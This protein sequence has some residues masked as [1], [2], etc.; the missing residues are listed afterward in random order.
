MPRA[1]HGAATVRAVAASV[2]AAVVLAVAAAWWVHHRVIPAER[3][4]LPAI[5]QTVVVAPLPPQSRPDL[6]E[7]PRDPVEEAWCEHGPEAVVRDTEPLARPDRDPAAAE[8]DMRHAWLRCEA[9]F[10]LGRVDQ[11]LTWSRRMVDALARPTPAQPVEPLVLEQHARVRL[12]AGESNMDKLE[13]GLRACV[14]ARQ[15][16]GGSVPDLSWAT[17]GALQKARGDTEQAV[18]SHDRALAGLDAPAWLAMR[19]REPWRLQL[20]ALAAMDRADS[21]VSLGR[22]ADARAAAIQLASD[23]AVALGEGEPLVQQAA[24]LRDSITGLK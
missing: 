22:Q 23:L 5:P 24:D 6:P 17:L 12:A 8:R 9:L 21:L 1:R 2:A 11:A 16:L 7:S 13:R 14:E 20:L 4:P 3:A 15:L 18:E 19:Q 10:T